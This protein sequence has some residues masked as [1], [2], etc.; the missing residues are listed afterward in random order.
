MNTFINELTMVYNYVPSTGATDESQYKLTL[1]Q[2][3]KK[4]M[5]VDFSRFLSFVAMLLDLDGSLSV[6][7][8]KCKVPRDNLFACS[9]FGWE[10]EKK[11]GYWHTRP[12]NLHRHR[13]RMLNLLY[14]VYL[15]SVINLSIAT[16]IYRKTWHILDI[17]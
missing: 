7:L 2:T 14:T 1:C 5:M 16:T 9:L 17:V 8:S 4:L 12:H 13:Q 11:V 15:P 10:K 3:S 6:L